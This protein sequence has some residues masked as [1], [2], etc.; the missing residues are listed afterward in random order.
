[1]EVR[2][3][4]GYITA[5]DGLAV[6]MMPGMEGSREFWRHSVESLAD[7]FMAVSCDLAV[8]KPSST[9][10]MADYAARTLGIMDE[11][12]IDG[13]VIAGESMGGMIAQQIALDHPEKVL[14]L[15]LCNTMDDPR[16]STGFGLNMFTLASFAHQLAFVPF[17][18]DAW[19]RRLLNWVGRHR[20]F[21]MDPTPGN[22]RLIDYLVAYGIA[23]GGMSYADKM[24]AGARTRYTDRLGEIAVPTLVIRGT[25]DRLVSAE[26]ALRFLGKIPNA[27]LALIEGGG[28]CCPHTMPEETTAAI[29]SWIERDVLPLTP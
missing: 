15:V 24:I 21:V 11:L 23:C 3:G 12:G 14:G 2:S 29:R 4:D 20:G 7:S 6:V 26:T 28:H 16:R 8:R 1:M 25:E 18:P 13:A 27:R 17:L 22:D 5:G 19:R 9:T 10:S